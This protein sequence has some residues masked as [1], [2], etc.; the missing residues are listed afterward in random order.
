MSRTFCE[1]ES[2]TGNKEALKRLLQ[3]VAAN[4]P[5]VGYVQGMNYIA[6]VL[7]LHCGEV[8]GYALYN[9]LLEKY[10]LQCVLKRGF[11]GLKVHNQRLEELGR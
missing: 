9:V 3:A 10:Q 7:L 8:L 4:K 6:A 5:I 11:P 1:E 2:F